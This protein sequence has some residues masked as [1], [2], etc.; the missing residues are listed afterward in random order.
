M[1][2]LVLKY[3]GDD[4]TVE[5]PVEGDSFTF[6]RGSDADQ[7]FEDSGLS[8]IHATIYREGDRVWIVDE[9]S[10]NGTFVNGRR[11]EGG[12]EPLEDGDIVKIGH[13][14][15][16]AVEF[17]EGASSDDGPGP[18]SGQ[19]VESAPPK[20]KPRSSIV[21]PA[22]LLGLAIL[23]IGGSL[24]FVAVI[25]AGG[26]K[27]ENT[28]AGGD[29]IADTPFS[30]L[31]TGSDE[32]GG[33][34][35]ADASPEVS[36][37]ATG[38]S[39][40]G[41]SPEFT[42]FPTMTPVFGGGPQNNIPAGKTYQQMSDAEKNEYV[43]TKAEV[44]SRVIGNS[45]GQA[46]PP[47]AVA[48]IRYFLD[49]YV[50]RIRSSRKDDCSTRGWTTSDMTSVLLRAKSNAP[51]IIRAF[52][53]KGIDPQIGL[54]LAMIES[55]HCECLQ[56]PTGP[57]GMFQFTQATAKRYGLE[58]KSGASPTNPD[59][60][61]EKKPAAEAAA[62]YMKALSGRIGTGPLSVPLAIASYNSGE[63]G[64]GKN[65]KTALEANE[66]QNRSFWTLVVNADKLAVQFQKENIR[67]VPKFFA[68]AIIGE[69]PRDFG[70]DLEPLSLYT[71]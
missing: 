52:N 5:I 15:N 30:D 49:A 53:E 9:N 63:G 56:S 8:R 1:F 13:Q 19:V 33:D 54:Y 25:M 27:G 14:T 16:I 32:T 46:I 60:R 2:E 43:K 37:S 70:I 51:F 28:T 66:S 18:E 31:P 11:V 4:G 38:I 40:T 62:S 45:S 57:L 50:R 35:G 17:R 41:P 23:V 12:G 10:S 6:G 55:E 48:K 21:L 64:L 3:S 34:N 7:R 69:N 44:V 47:V 36:P 61:C 26:F 58:V 71:K 68:A 24:I 22:V 42:P 20:D 65:L 29:N 67:Y 39:Q 59:Q